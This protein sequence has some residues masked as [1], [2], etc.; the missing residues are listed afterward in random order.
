M[1]IVVL[2]GPESAGKSTLAK[3]LQRAYGGLCCGE[4]VRAFIELHQRETTL[5]DIPAIARGQL[6]LEDQARATDPQWLWLDTH[7]L[8]NILWSERL[9]GSC[10]AWL[11]EALLE[12]RY[13]LHLLL[14][15][16][17]VP[18]IADGQRC[19]PDV[20]DRRAFFEACR[21]WLDHN[22][23]PYSV[24]TGDWATREAQAHTAIAR[25]F[26]ASACLP[27]VAGGR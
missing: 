5:A 7:L 25:F 12:R 13:D 24:L 21:R 3:R 8:S 9:F 17:G 4:Y 16:D 22:N 14:S 23:Q 27:G 26:G 10:P 2:T 11:Q 20:A 18:W 1:N 6:A 19:Q 15:P